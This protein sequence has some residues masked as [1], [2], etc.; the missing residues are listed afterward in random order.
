MIPGMWR[1]GEFLNNFLSCSTV[2]DFGWVNKDENNPSTKN[3]KNDSKPCCDSTKFEA[4]IIHYFYYRSIYRFVSILFGN[5]YSTPRRKSKWPHF[6]L[7]LFWK[8]TLRVWL[9]KV[10][11]VSFGFFYFL[12]SQD[13]VCKKMEKSHIFGIFY[14]IIP[15]FHTTLEYQPCGF[16]VCI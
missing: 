14:T 3:V 5:I 11:S 9:Q 1:S 8:N 4:T 15:H 16:N 13:I 12:L 6:T 2:K 10:Y 7:F